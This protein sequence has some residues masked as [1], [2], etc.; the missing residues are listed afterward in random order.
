L[1][2]AGWH[3]WSAEALNTYRGTRETVRGRIGV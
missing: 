1:M 3:P 2:R